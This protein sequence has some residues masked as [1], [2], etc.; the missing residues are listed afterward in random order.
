MSDVSFGTLNSLKKVQNLCL[1][2]FAKFFF[3]RFTFCVLTDNDCKS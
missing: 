1:R 2:I 3:A